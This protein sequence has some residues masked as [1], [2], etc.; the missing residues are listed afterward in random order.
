[1]CNFDANGCRILQRLCEYVIL[2]YKMKI[3]THNKIK[4]QI[5]FSTFYKN[6]RNSD[7]DWEQHIKMDNDK[8][9]KKIHKKGQTEYFYKVSIKLYLYWLV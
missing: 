3:Q 9:W 7:M 1:M 6:G 4:T 8:I 5:K 2:P